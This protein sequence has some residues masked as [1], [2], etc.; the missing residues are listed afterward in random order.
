MILSSIKQL[1]SHKRI[2]V[3]IE[4]HTKKAKT[5]NVFQGEQGY[6]DLLKYVLENGSDRQDRT[7]TGTL[8][9]FAPPSLKF[10]LRQGLPMYTTKRMAVKSVIEELLWFLR[11]DTDNALLQ[12]KKVR[13]WDGNTS[14]DYLSKK[15][16]QYREGVAGPIYGF[17]WRFFG[18]PYAENLADTSQIPSDKL[19]DLQKG[20]F[21]Q[22]AYLERMLRNDPLSRKIFMSAW[23][24]NDLSKM[25]LEP[26]HVSL[27][28]YVEPAKNSDSAPL[29]SGHVYI[30]SNDLFLGNPFNVLSYAILLHILAERAAMEPKEL[31]LSFGDAH[32][33]KDHVDQVRLQLTREP[34]ALPK[35]KLNPNVHGPISELTIND[36]EILNYDSYP[37]I[38]GKM[39]V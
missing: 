23:N 29:L 12:A 3:E 20:S 39:S 13:I 1:K 37:P 38:A 6:L 35:L 24:A 31:T 17:Q 32:I 22:I 36:F 5:M 27:Q 11:G 19:E 25:A 21:D 15:G 2:K 7:G 8:S 14:S 30:R 9:V 28:L 26:C 18:A 4:T 16:L 34:K 10:D 33:Y